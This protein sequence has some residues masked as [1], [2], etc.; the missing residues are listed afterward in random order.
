MTVAKPYK[1][2]CIMCNMWP[3]DCSCRKPVYTV[4]REC[5]RLKMNGVHCWHYNSENSM[6]CCDCGELMSDDL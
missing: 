6:F 4:Y 5:R 2:W 3:Y 1:L